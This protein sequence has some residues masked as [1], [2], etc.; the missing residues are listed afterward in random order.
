MKRAQII[1]QCQEAVSLF[2]TLDLSPSFL[3][4]QFL[5][6]NLPSVQR[7]NYPLFEKHDTLISGESRPWYGRCIIQ[8][9]AYHADAWHKVMDMV[10]TSEQREE[11]YMHEGRAS[12][13]TI[14]LVYQRQYGKDATPDR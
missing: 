12:A 10:C 6:L 14:N 9:H 3:N 11:A 2:S 5:I 1:M 8:F 4:S 7:I 13:A